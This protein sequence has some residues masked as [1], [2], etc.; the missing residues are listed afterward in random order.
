MNISAITQKRFRRFKEKKRAYWSLLFLA[1]LYVLSLGSELI[2]N[3]KPLYV[4]YNSKSY[5]PI[6]KYYPEDIFLNNDKQTRP[7]YKQV[8]KTSTFAAHAENFMI[9]PLIPYGP[10]ENIDAESLRSEEKVTLMMTPVP[11]VGNINIRPDFSIARSTS[12]GLFF[13]TKDDSVNGLTLG[14]YWDITPKLENAIKERFL[15]KSLP[16]ISVI[17]AS[18]PSHPKLGD[19]GK[20][21]PE[22][23]A[24][25]SLSKFSQRDS[26]PDTVR[27]SFR[28]AID[29]HT[30][31]FGEGV[32]PETIIFNRE[33]KILGRI[34]KLW[35][36]INSKE[37]NH[38]L[39]LANKRF[40]EY[41]EPFTFTIQNRIYKIDIDKNDI[42]WPHPPVRGHW[43][44]IDSNGRDV[45]ARIIYGL[46]ISMTFGFFLV[47]VSMFVGTFIGAIQGYYGGL[48]DITGQRIIEIWSALP[49]LYV[50]ILMG[51][52]YGRSFALLLFCYGI[53]N[54]IGISYYMRGEFLRLRKQPFV[55]S[56]KCIGISPFKIIIRHILP[57]AL[58]PVITFF[59][60]YLVG[61]IGSLAALDFLGF[62]LPPP[63]P[64]WGELLHQ[65]Q[66]FR[67]AWWLILYPSLT[68]FIV[69]LLGIFVGE[70][71]RDAFD[72]RPYSRME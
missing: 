20:I 31:D 29:P 19:G 26:S 15:N 37:R 12:C 52:I 60:F 30:K 28:E 9:F 70:G 53:F 40:S 22:L 25:I 72:P 7:N 51:S 62:G 59:P 58:T 49:F 33:M 57:N 45:L 64:S 36:E 65:A 39:D 18:K 5:F 27:I 63:T 32:K 14:N 38:L 41:L 6:F 50:M 34:S 2:C 54:W 68:L 16:S 8:N 4:R 35:E 42:S 47:A 71:V 3:D 1:V 67:W 48:L 61:A 23:K 55:D 44:G 69:M 46:R 21:N 11:Q 17:S 56:A 10:Y 66:Q 43:L 13:N 24:E